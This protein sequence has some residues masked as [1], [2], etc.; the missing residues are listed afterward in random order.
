[1]TRIRAIDDPAQVSDP[2]YAEGL[3][4]AVEAALGY[5]L[6]CLAEG[7]ER[8]PLVPPVLLTQAQLAVR[9]SVS[10][11]TVLRR[12]FAGYSLLG[13]SLVTEAEAVGLKGGMLKAM[14]REQSTVFDRLVHAIGEAYRSEE[15]GRIESAERRRAKLVD[16]VL[17]GQLIDHSALAYD[18]EAFHLAVVAAG[19]EAARALRELATRLDRRLLLVT[20]GDAAV[21]A[22]LGGRLSFSERPLEEALASDWPA[23]I[24]LGLGE[25]AEGI[26]GWRL[27]HRQAQA[28]FAVALRCGEPAA[29]YGDVALFASML[30]DDLLVS[31]LHRLYLEPLACD[32]DEGATLRATLRAYFAARRNV[33]SAASAL[34]VSRKTVNRRLR[35]IERRLGRQLH[36]CTAEVEAALL[37]VD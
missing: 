12:Y 30:Q 16:R 17:A 2:V 9:S 8:D 26:L 28:A 23:A 18:L 20:R 35:A 10:L 13:D 24:R 27:S 7:Q 36:T 4:E 21:W 32:S 11:D 37:L 14:M 19:P 25:P 33:S 3:R 29:R 5:G 34:G 22:W 31:S 6:A 1:M 15:A